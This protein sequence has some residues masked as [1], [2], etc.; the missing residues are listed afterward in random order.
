MKQLY[1]ISIIVLMGLSSVLN[2]QNVSSHYFLD[3]LPESSKLNPAFMP[4]CKFYLDLPGIGNSYFGLT[5]DIGIQDVLTSA[6][7]GDLL[8]LPF[9][10]P[11]LMDDFL[12]TLS[13]FSFLETEANINLLGFGFKTDYGYFHFNTSERFVSDIRLPK[14]LFQLNQLADK[15]NEYYGASHD[16]SGMSMNLTV[17]QEISAGLTY[18]LSSSLKVGGKVKL[19]LG[20]ANT[21]LK[22]NEFVLSTSTKEVSIDAEIVARQS[23]PIKMTVDEDD[24][25]MIDESEEFVF[26]EDALDYALAFQNLGF[27]VDLGVEYMLLPNLSLS[28]SVVDLGMIRWK[29]NTFNYQAEGDGVFQGVDEMIVYDEEN[30]DEYFENLADSLSDQYTLGHDFDPYSTS[31]VPKLYIGAEYQFSDVFSAGILGKTRFYESG[32]RENVYFSANLNLYHF[33]TA[34]A[35]YNWAWSEPNT[36]GFTL[37]LKLFPLQVY[38]ST[39]MMPLAYRYY[40]MDGKDFPDMS[41]R[42]PLPSKFN[43]FNAQ[44]G[45]NLMFGCRKKKNVPL[46]ELLGD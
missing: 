29:S 5:S 32:L 8:N 13:K 23:S 33:L 37:A 16:L 12:G 28:A 24:V 35:H 15:D 22:M 34:G 10:N 17:F 4:N 25:P 27:A 21:R 36:M 30:R 9:N 45:V 2:G 41:S 26:E 42:L 46:Y 20:H 31:L 18:D 39:D 43:G 44:V 3:N 19:L 38:L 11:A 7:N 40:A 1:I 6:N 14:A